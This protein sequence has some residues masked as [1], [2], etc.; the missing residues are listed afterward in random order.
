MEVSRLESRVQ[1][2]R[3]DCSQDWIIDSSL[4]LPNK[5]KKRLQTVF[6]VRIKGRGNVGILSLRYVDVFK[7]QKVT[8]NRW[9]KRQRTM[10]MKERRQWYTP[11]GLA[12]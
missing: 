7:D 12:V 2:G 8:M 3:R 11:T 10:A 9:R 5:A 4:L 1:E 6:F